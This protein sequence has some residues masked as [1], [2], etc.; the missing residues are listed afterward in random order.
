M[1]DPIPQTEDEL[2]LVMQSLRQKAKSMSSVV[3]AHDKAI[4]LAA[5]A[6]SKLVKAHNKM[7]SAKV[8]SLALWKKR[9]ADRVDPAS[10]GTL[11]GPQTPT[12]SPAR[13]PHTNATHLSGC[14]RPA[15]AEVLLESNVQLLLQCHLQKL[16]PGPEVPSR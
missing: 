10:S 12:T 6:T 4:N 9:H 15:Q 13:P 5:R 3:Q 1:G 2:R 11:L 14:S 16:P 7:V 8:D